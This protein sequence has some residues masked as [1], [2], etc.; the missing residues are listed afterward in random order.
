ML[1]VNRSDWAAG[2]RVQD[3]S[4]RWWND[5]FG[6]DPQDPDGVL[7]QLRH[8]R[9]Q[10]GPTG[11]V[12]L[13]VN[14]VAENIA[15]I[16]EADLASIA[17]KLLRRVWGV[18]WRNGEVTFDTWKKFSKPLVADAASDDKGVTIPL[19]LYRYS[20]SRKGPH[21]NLTAMIRPLE[22]P[23]S[24]FLVFLTI[25]ELKDIRE[26]ILMDL[27]DFKNLALLEFN[28]P[29]DSHADRIGDRLVR[30]W[31]EKTSPFPALK[32]LRITDS[33]FLSEKSICYV[34]KFPTLCVYDMSVGE[35]EITVPDAARVH[36]WKYTRP[37][38][39]FGRDPAAYLRCLVRFLELFFGR[40]RGGS[41]IS[42]MT[43][44]LFSDRLR[45]YQAPVS[46][47]PCLDH[48]RSDSEMSRLEEIWETFMEEE[49][50]EDTSSSDEEPGQCSD[51][52]SDQPSGI[53]PDQPSGIQPNQPS[54]YDHDQPSEVGSDEPSDIETDDLP[55]DECNQS[56][57]S[58]SGQL[59]YDEYNQCS[60]AE[61]NYSWKKVDGSFWATLV[62]A[63]VDH[64]DLRAGGKAMM[65]PLNRSKPLPLPSKPFV[66]L[67]LSKER[68]GHFSIDE[69]P[70]AFT[71]F[72]FYRPPLSDR[73]E[74]ACNA[75]IKAHHKSR[76]E[77]EN[78]RE[79]EH[80]HLKPRKRRNIGDML[81]SL[82][83]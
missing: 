28:G 40:Q 39:R 38:Y 64:S 7:S 56:P 41:A 52:E 31:S 47:L 1:Y 44:S 30:G 9:R 70:G 2:R 37:S 27:A 58:E 32:V 80:R 43:M 24:D 54:N 5:R 18:V 22:A 50:E 63:L 12:T 77:R 65:K 72:T 66:T 16:P 62:Y 67:E 4:Q 35:S 33:T 82:V 21:E 25:R 26:E 60:D 45:F 20:N 49:E 61:N 13:C 73:T 6:S 81:N 10:K 17:A 57:D 68:Q 51:I 3:P 79:N 83:G 74:C 48:R 71:N 53:E 46:F 15:D 76:L 29:Q 11:L 55:D 42:K 8:R 23:A 59:S 78:K 14:E 34:S 75:N 36:G 19:E 69:Q